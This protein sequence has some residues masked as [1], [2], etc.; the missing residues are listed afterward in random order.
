VSTTLDA[1][2][3]A[4][5]QQTVS[6]GGRW[7]GFDVDHLVDVSAECEVQA[8]PHVARHVAGVTRLGD[9]IRPVL[10]LPRFLALPAPGRATCAVCVA[11]DELEIVILAD[12]VGEVLEV[13]ALQPCDD[14]ALAPWARGAVPGTAGSVVLL[15]L[16]RILEA[17]RV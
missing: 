5:P 10:D 11:V 1:R 17:A 16:P 14:D 4:P 13:S 3:S 7:L 6:I 15:D 9:R 2:T 12:D 8:L